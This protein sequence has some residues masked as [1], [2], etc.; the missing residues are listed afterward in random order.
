MVS[1]LEDEA[2]LVSQVCSCLT[3]QNHAYLAQSLLQLECALSHG[4]EQAGGIARQKFCVHRCSF[5]TGN[6]GPG[7]PNGQVASD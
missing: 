7:A 4:G 6:D 5:D 3:S 1:R 2:E